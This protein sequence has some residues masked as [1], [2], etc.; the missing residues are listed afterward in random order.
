[1]I[2]Q[3]LVFTESILINQNEEVTTDFGRTQAEIIRN[4]RI[5]L[6]QGQELTSL[7]MFIEW[8]RFGGFS[9]GTVQATL[10]GRKIADFKWP[11]GRTEPIIFDQNIDKNLIKTDGSDNEL[12]IRFFQGA[13]DGLNRWSVTSQITYNGNTEQAP[14]KPPQVDP[15]IIDPDPTKGQSVGIINQ[16]RE[17]LFGDVKKTVTTLAIG[18]LVIGGVVITVKLLKFSPQGRAVRLTKAAV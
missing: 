12:V 3:Q 5:P 15:P 17:A 4:F 16:V 14:S 6:D 18:A 8:D 13:F 11:I 1:M 9:D 7:L 2:H 10:N